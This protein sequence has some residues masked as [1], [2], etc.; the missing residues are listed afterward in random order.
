MMLCLST[1]SPKCLPMIR[2][3][4]LCLVW[5]IMHFQCTKTKKEQRW[6]MG[7]RYLLDAKCCNNICWVIGREA[8]HGKG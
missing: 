4:P 7:H 5:Q 3:T 6:G 2:R 1:L 8:S